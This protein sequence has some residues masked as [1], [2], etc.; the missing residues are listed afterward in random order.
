MRSRILTDFE[1]KAVARYLRTN[2]VRD[3]EVRSIARYAKKYLDQLRRDLELIERFYK[4][5]RQR[6]GGKGSKH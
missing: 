3:E 2:G 1:R 6:D 4:V 5:Y